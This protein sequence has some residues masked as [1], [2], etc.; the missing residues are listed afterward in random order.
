MSFA[1]KFAFCSIGKRHH[2]PQSKQCL[3]ERKCKAGAAIAS[4]VSIAG[5]CR[6]RFRWLTQNCFQPLR[7]KV[8]CQNK[9]PLSI[10]TPAFSS[11]P[12]RRFRVNTHLLC[13]SKCNKK[14]CL[15]NI[16]NAFKNLTN[17]CERASDQLSFGGVFFRTLVKQLLFLSMVTKKTETQSEQER[18][19]VRSNPPKML[20][21]LVPFLQFT[22]DRRSSK[23]AIVSLC[24]V[25][26]PQVISSRGVGKLL[27]LLVNW[28]KFLARK[29]EN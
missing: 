2:K 27:E 7:L 8:N 23:I 12:E 28:I 18:K 26:V 13:L 11:L 9:K 10:Q 3:V 21:V 19:W 6:W 1:H 25:I 15:E 5:L 14:C 29:K 16:K 4:E 22:N 17:T 24:P 20:S